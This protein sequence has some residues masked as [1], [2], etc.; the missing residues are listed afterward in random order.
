MTRSLLTG[1]DVRNTWSPLS[2]KLKL[3]RYLGRYSSC[4][5]S[6]QWSRYGASW[7]QHWDWFQ[8]NA[9]RQFYGVSIYGCCR[10]HLTLTRH[11]SS[12]SPAAFRAT[13]KEGTELAGHSEIYWLFEFVLFTKTCST[14]IEN[15]NR[16]L[17][18]FSTRIC[19]WHA[20]WTVWIVWIGPSLNRCSAEIFVS[21][22]HVYPYRLIVKW[23]TPLRGT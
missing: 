10:R 2:C 22:Y 15:I 14:E 11:W 21:T 3:Q 12:Q 19:I 9:D 1:V 16:K 13:N 20:L 23:T 8:W 17:E 4:G 6:F 7:L 5:L 18:K